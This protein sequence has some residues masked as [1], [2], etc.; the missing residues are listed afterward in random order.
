ML[1][2]GLNILT[3]SLSV[4]CKDLMCKMLCPKV[5]SRIKM[6]NIF[7]HL[8]LSKDL[9]HSFTPHPF[10][11]HLSKDSINMEIVSHMVHTI[12]LEGMSEVNLRHNHMLVKCNFEIVMYVG[13]CTR[14][15]AG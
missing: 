5:E 1:I 10:P 6:E 11:N 9:K 15:I 14:S 13:T 12:K 7:Q 2:S 4:E 3:C 8:W